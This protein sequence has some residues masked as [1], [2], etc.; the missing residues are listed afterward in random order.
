[1]TV[2]E[3]IEELGKYPEDMIVHMLVSYDDGFG[4]AG[5]TIQYIEK[6]DMV[7]LCNDEG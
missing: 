4:H 5:G 7:Y 6:E 3:L 2:K 1:M